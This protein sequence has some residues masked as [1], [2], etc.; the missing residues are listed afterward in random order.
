MSHLVST[1]PQDMP[2]NKFISSEDAMRLEDIELGKSKLSL[3][4]A[5]KH[6]NP[7]HNFN[8]IKSAVL[9]TQKQK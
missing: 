1:S 6:R 2:K 9:S 7:F 5:M 4:H 8:Q 3:L